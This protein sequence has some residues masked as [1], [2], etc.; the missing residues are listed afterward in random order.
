MTV[1]PGCASYGEVGTVTLDRL[2]SR[3]AGGLEAPAVVET[4][5]AGLS[6]HRLQAPSG[7]TLWT[8]TRNIPGH[9][10]RT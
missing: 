3:H 6:N 2:V 9:E 7:L 4:L 8:S 10:R 1:P 5:P